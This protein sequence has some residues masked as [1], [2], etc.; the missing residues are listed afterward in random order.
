MAKYGWPST[1]KLKQG[2][3][4]M[5]EVYVA[6]KRKG[7]VHKSWKKTWYYAGTPYHSRDEAIDALLQAKGLHPYGRPNVGQTQRIG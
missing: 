7:Y 1:L 5:L 2:K 6:G 4:G 3:H